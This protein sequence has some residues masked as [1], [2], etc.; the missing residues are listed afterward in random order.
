MT[1]L[2]LKSKYNGQSVL[3]FSIALS[4]SV[5]S[6]VFHSEIFGMGNNKKKSYGAKSLLSERNATYIVLRQKS[7]PRPSLNSFTYLFIAIVVAVVVFLLLGFFG[8]R[9][10]KHEFNGSLDVA[11]LVAQRASDES[12]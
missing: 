5:Y 10:A 3:V 2:F 6:L 7:K 4:A 9:E 8:S 11:F 12:L 1:L